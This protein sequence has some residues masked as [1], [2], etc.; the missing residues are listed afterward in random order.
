MHCECSRLHSLILVFHLNFLFKNTPT[1]KDTYV[2][3]SYILYL[4]FITTPRILTP[5]NYW[6]HPL[7]HYFYILVLISLFNQS[8]SI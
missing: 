3:D 5:I 6:N 2:V 1:F 7:S 8:D 4:L